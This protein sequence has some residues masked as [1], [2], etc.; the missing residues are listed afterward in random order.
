[1]NQLLNDAFVQPAEVPKDMAMSVYRVMHNQAA[2]EDWELF[3]SYIRKESI[4]TVL[5][6][7]E[8]TLKAND[9]SPVEPEVQWWRGQLER[10][11]ERN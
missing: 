2:V 9:V 4:D 11:V 5:N 10:S 7:I 8:N 1:M 6:W 3:D